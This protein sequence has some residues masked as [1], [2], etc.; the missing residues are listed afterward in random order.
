MLT[1][2]TYTKAFQYSYTIVQSGFQ[3]SRCL[4]NY[5]K[6][7][8]EINVDI[9]TFINFFQIGNNRYK[10]RLQNHLTILVAISFPSYS[11]LHRGNRYCL[12]LR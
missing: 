1:T 7:N 12:D 5:L 10:N 9:F 11:F 8:L 6:N 4:N 2:Q 3:T